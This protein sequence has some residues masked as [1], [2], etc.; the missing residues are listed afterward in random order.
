MATTAARYPVRRAIA[1]AVKLPTIE[2]IITAVDLPAQGF[3]R[4]NTYLKVRERTSYAFALV[5]VAVA[6]DMEGET[7]TEARLALNFP[8]QD[9]ARLRGAHHHDAPL[10]PAPQPVDVILVENPGSAVERSS[11]SS[12]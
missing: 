12:K 9:Q 7:I 4:H 6:L 5:S 3:A 2:E 11:G 8:D 1:A 10:R